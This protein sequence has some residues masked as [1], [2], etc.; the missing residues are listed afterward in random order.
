MIWTIVIFIAVL[1][2]LVFVHELGH[3]A[4]AKLLGISVE[5]FGF[6]FPPR[7][8]GVKFKDTIYSLNWIPLGGFV[9]IKGEAGENSR[10]RDS[11]ASRGTGARALV[12]GAGVT[13][14]LLLAWMLL[15]A[16]FMLGLPQALENLPPSARVISTEIQ[17][18]SVLPDSPAS[19]AGIKV[20]DVIAQADSLPVADPD[21]F[22]NFTAEKEGAPITLA[23]V[24]S[25]EPLELAVTPEK[26]SG[27]DR[28]GIGIAVMRTGLVSYPWYIA[29]VQGLVTTGYL[30]KAIFGAFG[31]IIGDLFTAHKVSVDLS[32]PVGIAVMTAEVMEMGFLHLLQFVA[33]LS[34]NLAV[35]NILPFPALDGGRLFFLALERLRRR[36][37]A[38]RV[39]TMI[40]NIGFMILITLVLVITA[41]DVLKFGDRILGAASSIFGS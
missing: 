9:K 30:V 41:R 14:N 39:E 29:P 10:D 37:V 21:S 5:E 32:G 7:I 40:H 36:P 17:V 28:A 24:R 8:F 6:G 1:S 22:R 11:F 15:S 23:L 33:L 38:A 12:I 20:G 27:T 19:R 26:L 31:G 34:I 3:F 16:G 18:Y 35:I 4:T 25:G 13:M 2:L